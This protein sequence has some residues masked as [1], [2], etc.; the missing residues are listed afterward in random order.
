MDKEGNLTH[1]ILGDALKDKDFVYEVLVPHD[2]WYAAELMD[3]VSY[4]LFSAVVIPGG[5]KNSFWYVIYS[6][7]CLNR[8]LSN[9]ITWLFQ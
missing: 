1:K 7:T 9:P 2:T 5:W 3:D 8:Y 4:V 6:E